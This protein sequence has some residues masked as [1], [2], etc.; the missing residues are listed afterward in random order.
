M[1]QQYLRKISER[2]KTCLR[3]PGTYIFEDI[4]V[5][6]EIK[7]LKENILR[8][9]AGWSPRSQMHIKYL[10]YNGNES[11]NSLLQEYGILSKDNEEADM[12]RPKQCPNCN[13]PN[14][15]DQKFAKCKMVLTY[16]AYNE[17]LEKENQKESELK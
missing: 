13:E 14:R 4:A 8:Q 16:D 6:Q 17:T 5:S 7:Y 11:S 15:P 3:N 1:T 10:H 2:L 12:L 9:H